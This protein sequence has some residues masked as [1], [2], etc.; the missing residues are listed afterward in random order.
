MSERFAELPSGVRLCYETFGDSRDP[1]VLLVMGL[2]TQMLAWHEDFCAMLVD[3][4]YFVIRF[5]NRDC[6]RSSTMRGRPPKPLELLTRRV[7][8]SYKLRDMAADA[9]GLL[10][11]LDISAAHV[12]G[13]SMG[14][15]I[16]QVLA[17]G[18]P[19]RV[20]SLAS[21]MSTTGRWNVGRP[22][23]TTYAVLLRVAPTDRDGYID[24][25]TWVVEKIGS[26]DF[27]RDEA[28]LRERAARSF[29]RGLH[30]AGTGRQLA[31]IIA[32]ADR[33]ARLG[34]LRLPAVVIH[35][36]RDR[37]VNIS[38]G[39]AT[40]RAIPGAKLVE[41]EGMG[42]DL[43]R[44]TWPQ[45]VEAITEVAARARSMPSGAAA[46]RPPGRELLR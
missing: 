31:A 9:L 23:L 36:T 41:I 10:D 28:E 35:G 43:P 20:L 19:E 45:V 1:A 13:A 8:A 22:A 6:G 18:H 2:G 29:D 39:R 4:G 16:A 25:L 11:A 5:D 44:G 34:D 7:H 30:P 17:I 46:Q 37:L 21:I 40:A 24:H 12:V 38:G 26:P 15:M 27:P 14:G 33:T 42:H 32:S 3:R